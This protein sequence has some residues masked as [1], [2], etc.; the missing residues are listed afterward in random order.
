[1]LIFI[2]ILLLNK[3]FVCMKTCGIAYILGKSRTWLYNF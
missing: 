2:R 3:L 1:M